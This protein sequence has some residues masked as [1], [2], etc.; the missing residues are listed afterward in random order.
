MLL[1]ERIWLGIS[2]L[3]GVS[4]DVGLGP[5]NLAMTEASL[6]AIRTFV[7]LYV[8][9]KKLSSALLFLLSFQGIHNHTVPVRLNF[10]RHGSTVC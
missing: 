10:Q 9:Q 4:V 5:A 2:T 7:R 3:S 1:M 8:S 6:A